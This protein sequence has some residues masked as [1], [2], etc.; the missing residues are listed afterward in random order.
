MKN[1]AASKCRCVFAAA[2][3]G[4]ALCVWAGANPAMARPGGGQSYA[5]SSSS[6]SYSSS[7]SSSSSSSYASGSVSSGG[8]GG[9][10]AP[11]DPVVLLFALVVLG[12]LMVVMVINGR[13]TAKQRA[14]QQARDTGLPPDVFATLAR[15]AGLLMPSLDG[16]RAT[17]RDEVS[18]KLSAVRDIDPGFSRPVFDDFVHALFVKAHEARGDGRLDKLAIYLDPHARAGLASRGPRGRAGAGAGGG[19]RLFMAG[20]GTADTETLPVRDVRGV[21]VGAQ[22]ICRVRVDPT[23]GLTTVAVAFEANYTEQTDGGAQN[24]YVEELW[25]FQRHNDVRSPAPDDMSVHRCPSCGAGQEQ[26]GDG[27]CA[28]CG[29][30]IDTGAFSWVVKAALELRRSPRPPQLTGDVPEHGTE[31]PT[32]VHPHAMTRLAALKDRDPAFDY[33]AFQDRVRLVYHGLNLAWTGRRWEK[34]RPYLTN[35]QFGAQR[36]WIDEYLRQGLTNHMDEATVTRIEVAKVESD[37]YFDAITVRVHAHAKD[38]TTDDKT[39]AIVSGGNLYPRHYTEY[40]TFIR[41]S[42]VAQPTTTTESCPSCGAGLDDITMAGECAHCGAT[43]T[44]GAFDWVLSRIEQ[45]EAYRG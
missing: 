22:R 27:A 43:I 3:L 7:S 15:Q 18:S 38:F 5:G 6:G 21:I 37:Q 23:L 25:I 36:Y 41:R 26:S 10:R 40:W 12:A 1:V 34:A 29:K 33:L 45:D 8:G 16:A 9:E 39:G 31:D 13:K 14:A 4:G 42:G 28:Y 2:L 24:Q 30:R 20:P 35:E 32:I 44:K 11:A 19:A 17:A